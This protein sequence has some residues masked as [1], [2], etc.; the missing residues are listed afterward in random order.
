MEGWECEEEQGQL[1]VGVKGLGNCLVRQ[2]LGWERQ[3]Q[4]S[5]LP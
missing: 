4:G 5:L 2:R 3:G 1:K